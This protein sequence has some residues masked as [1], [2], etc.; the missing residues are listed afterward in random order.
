[1]GQYKTI[2]LELIQQQPELCE[3]LRVSRTLLTTLDDYATALRI[4]HLSWK[5]ELR[6]ANSGY[7]PRQ[8]SAEALE[9]AIESLRERLPSASPAS[10]EGEGLSLDDAMSFLRRHSPPA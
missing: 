4:S 1:M 10:E 3:Q 6:Q 7:D 2:A 9:M 5:E 8:V